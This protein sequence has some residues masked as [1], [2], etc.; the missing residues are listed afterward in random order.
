M[1]APVD[2][3]Q[4]RRSLS[5]DDCLD[6]LAP[7]GR[8]RVAATMKAAPVI[9]PVTFALLG[10]DVV[11]RPRPSDGLSRALTNAVVAFE[12]DDV[13]SDGRTRWE[14]HVTAVAGTHIGEGGVAGF[15]LSSEIMTGWRATG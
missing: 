7:G 4:A 13:D 5:R 6:L 12:T 9:I 1:R 2:P 14:V 10:E 15:R 11:V 3:G 8:G